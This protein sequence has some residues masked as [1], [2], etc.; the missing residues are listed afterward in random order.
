M[1]SFWAG[2]PE[3]EK[4]L[5]EVRAT[6]LGRAATD[7]T[8]VHAA[9]RQLLESSGKM[10]RP[11]FVL[12][13]SRFGSAAI[14]R[15]RMIGIAAAVE[16]LHMATLVHDDI[17]DGA[18]L[19]RGIATLHA[20]KGPRVAVLVG[21]WLFAACFSLVADFARME[22]A[23]SLSQLVARIC[24]SELSQSADRFVLHTSIRRYKRRIA[25]KTAVLFALSFYVG[26]VESECPPALCDTLRRL[27]YCLG[28]GFQIIDDILDFR[29]TGGE[30]GKPT[31]SDLSQ[32]ILTLPAILELGADE[33]R[34]RAE[35][36]A[37]KRS[38]RAATRAAKIIAE[39]G[40]L[41]KARLHAETYTCRALHE[42]DRLPEGEAR[43]TLRE[44]TERL[45]HRTY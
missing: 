36:V 41:E 11:A 38:P 17:I 6:I 8:E 20:L 24:A 31:G 34:L 19:R 4:E 26:A 42:I 1:Q 33:G 5:E 39:R 35:L 12:V 9:I 13:S 14:E 23:R 18:A 7:D 16:M 37:S 45:L 21:D 2:H 32:G 30:T 44:A 10:L 25:G 3:I 27:G 15:S 40:G 28:M 29:Q 43:T 22:N